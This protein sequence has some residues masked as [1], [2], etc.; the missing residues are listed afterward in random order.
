VAYSLSVQLG[1]A[2]RKRS[3]RNKSVSPDADDL[4]LR[5][6]ADALMGTNPVRIQQRLD[7]Y[8]QAL[9]LDAD[10]GEA[11]A[12][13]AR[14]LGVLIYQG[15]SKSPADDLRTAMECADRALALDPDNAKAVYA[16]GH[17]FLIKRDYAAALE[18][19]E[20]A[21]RLNPS[22]PVTHQFVGLAKIY[23][24]RSDESI[25]HLSEA[26]RLSPRDYNI[27]D[28]YV[29]L[30]GA[31][32]HLARFAEAIDWLDRALRQNPRIEVTH[33]YLASAKLRLGRP[34]EAETAIKNV[35]A[36]NPSLSV[37][38]VGASPIVGS[39]AMPD[40]LDD[41]RKAGLPD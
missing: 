3:E 41:L 4:I 8:Q 2:E 21:V 38:A 34:H 24:G 40:F 27:A 15:W 11:L 30:G 39:V 18:A 28:F 10:N 7:L 14:N 25:E 33:L 17:A 9:K 35:L 23:L 12:G 16:R 31:C 20:E 5:A 6:S 19:Y 1:R 32:W 29:S 26:I 22:V 36:I 13:V 37:K